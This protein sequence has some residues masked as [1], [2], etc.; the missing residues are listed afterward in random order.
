VILIANAWAAYDTAVSIASENGRVAIVSFLGRGEEPLD[1][2][3]L[4]MDRF[5]IKGFS[6]HADPIIFPTRD[7]QD[8]GQGRHRP[9]LLSLMAAGL[10]EPRRLVTHRFHYT[11]IAEPYEMALRRDKSMMNVVF[12]WRDA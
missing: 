7:P 5:Y 4:S 8:E 2:N 1:F 3:P 6:L 9:H 11:Q 10:L 12:D